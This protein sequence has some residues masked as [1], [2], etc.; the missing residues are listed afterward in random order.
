MGWRML[1]TVWVVL[2]VLLPVTGAAE[3]TRAV[4]TVE[5][6]SCPFCAYGVEKKLKAVRGAREVAVDMKEGTATLVAEEG[7][8]LDLGQIGKAVRASGF[9]PGPLKITAIGTVK[10]EEEG[11]LLDVRNSPQTFHL[12]NPEPSVEEHL[13]AL[14]GTEKAVEISGVAHEHVDDLPTMMP[15][16]VMEV[17]P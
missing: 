7:K 11:L 5:G 1:S 9:T 17:A 3:V 6:M 2:L 4:V 14:A 13:R 12:V 10:D 8:S 15:E 16:T